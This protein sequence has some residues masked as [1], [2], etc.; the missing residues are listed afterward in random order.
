MVITKSISELKQEGSK[1]M[2]RK[3]FINSVYAGID[4]L[5]TV[6]AEIASL[7]TPNLDYEEFKETVKK[8][9][10]DFLL[11]NSTITVS[12]AIMNHIEFLENAKTLAKNLLTLIIDAGMEHDTVDQH[13]A[14]KE[15]AKSIMIIWTL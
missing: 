9:G 13:E 11:D 7:D 3:D 2:S 6:K 10:F 12:D 8:Q 14:K 5:R 1:V 15:I 4:D